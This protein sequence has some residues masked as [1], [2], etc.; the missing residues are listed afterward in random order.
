[1]NI[2][3]RKNTLYVYLPE[4]ID[5]PLLNRMEDRINNIMGTYNIDKLEI[6]TTEDNHSHL[7]DFESRYNRTHDSSIVIK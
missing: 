6:R 2:I 7:R 3:Y 1:M 4:N 5:N